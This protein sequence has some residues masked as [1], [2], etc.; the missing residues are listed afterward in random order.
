[1]EFN[2]N[3]ANYDSELNLEDELLEIFFIDINNIFLKLSTGFIKYD[4]TK[5]ITHEIKFYKVVNN[6]KELIAEVTSIYFN[7]KISFKINNK[8]YYFGLIASSKGELFISS[9]IDENN[10]E[11]EITCDLIRQFEESILKICVLLK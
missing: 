3:I 2:D 1:M 11:Y 4:L 10:E 5:K 8:V 9:E 6:Q 7:E